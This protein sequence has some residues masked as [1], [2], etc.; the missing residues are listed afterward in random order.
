MLVLQLK[1]NMFDFVLTIFSI[2]ILNIK[3]NSCFA[4]NINWFEQRNMLLFPVKSTVFVN[5]LSKQKFIQLVLQ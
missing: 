4:K 3:C 1:Q 2:S 5:A